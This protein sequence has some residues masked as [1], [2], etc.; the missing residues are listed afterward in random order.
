MPFPIILFN[1]GS[2]QILYGEEQAVRG[3]I[4]LPL[5][6]LE[7]HSILPSHL[8][9][10]RGG[11]GKDHPSAFPEM[12]FSTHQVL[13]PFLCPGV[14]DTS[15]QHRRNLESPLVSR[16]ETYASNTASPPRRPSAQRDVWQT[17]LL[18]GKHTLI[19]H[20]LFKLKPTVHR[21]M[22]RASWLVCWVQWPLWPHHNP[23]HSEGLVHRCK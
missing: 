18:L 19:N 20:S 23:V 1:A 13:S 21:R 9:S 3:E 22:S 14:T 7:N 2:F 16:R 11:G 17:H 6:S 5:R 4:Q 8:K 15:M 10:R 12:I